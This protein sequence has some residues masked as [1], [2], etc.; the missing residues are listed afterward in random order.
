MSDS[1]QNCQ[2]DWEYIS[3]VKKTRQRQ[4]MKADQFLFRCR[5]CARIDPRSS[6]HGPST[7]TPVGQGF[8]QPGGRDLTK[9]IVDH[10][11]PF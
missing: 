2:H 8:A 7:V 10:E 4:H 1:I 3:F 9:D 11:P 6:R 5:K